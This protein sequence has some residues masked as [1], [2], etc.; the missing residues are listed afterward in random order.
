LGF[1]IIAEG[2][3]LKTVS[4]VSEVASSLSDNT[5]KLESDSKVFVLAVPEDG[6]MGEITLVY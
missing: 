1:V 6:K 3:N 5:F 2:E 4:Q